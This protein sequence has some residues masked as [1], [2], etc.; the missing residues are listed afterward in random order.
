M[1]FIW[2]LVQDTGSPYQFSYVGGHDET[3]TNSYRWIPSG[4]VVPL[5]T[6]LWGP[7]EPNGPQERHMA[8]WLD[9]TGHLM[10]WV[11]IVGSTELL[12]TCE[13]P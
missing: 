1:H 6:A 12:F 8:Y 3:G 13:A 2:I 7:G 5:G 4:D 9:G 11:D 10:A